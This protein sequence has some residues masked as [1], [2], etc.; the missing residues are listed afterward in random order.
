VR[1][2]KTL[3][4]LGGGFEV[5]QIGERKMVRSVPHEFSTDQAALLELAQVSI[6]LTLT[7]WHVLAMTNAY[8]YVI[9]D[10]EFHHQRNGHH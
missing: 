3:K 9:K 8:I 2:I 7:K 1:S 10:T 4:P 6:D 5:I